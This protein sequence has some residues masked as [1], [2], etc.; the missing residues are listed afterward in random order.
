MKKS[1]HASCVAVR[2]MADV[3]NK[4]GWIAISVGDTRLLDSWIKTLLA[5]VLFQLPI[6]RARGVWC[7]GV[8][9]FIVTCENDS[10]VKM[11]G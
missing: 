3:F 2:Q 7:G 5:A 11:E 1:P 4:R 8:S 6:K 9:R 10:P